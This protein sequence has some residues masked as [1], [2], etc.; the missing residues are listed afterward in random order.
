MG[1]LFLSVSSIFTESFEPLCALCF[2]F[3][4]F[5]SVLFIG[6]FNLRRIMENECQ[7]Y[8]TRAR[9]THIRMA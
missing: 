9:S 1:Y 6:Y 3:F 2:L 7:T 4:H 5:L 8:M